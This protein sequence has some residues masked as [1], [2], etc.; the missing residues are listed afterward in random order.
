ANARS[1]ELSRYAPKPA[2]ATPRDAGAPGGAA[3]PPAFLA[4]E[5]ANIAAGLEL[6]T[7]RSGDAATVANVLNRVR[8]LRGVA[9]VKEVAPLA[10][11][12]YDDGGAGVIE[13]S[14]NPPT[15]SSER[16]RLELVSLGE[17]LRQVVD[18]ARRANDGVSINR[19]RRDLRGALRALQAAAASFGEREIA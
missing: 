1:A 9:G 5:A 16:F 10:E 8:G 17:H 3:S 18:A 11:L 13:Q 14:Q 7:T 15:S 4:T 19:A 6:L 12:F 2:S